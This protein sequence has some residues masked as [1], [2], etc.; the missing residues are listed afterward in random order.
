MPHTSEPEPEPTESPE[1]PGASE[2]SPEPL[3]INGVPSARQDKNG[4]PFHWLRGL[5]S[6]PKSP[7]E[8]TLREALEEVIEEFEDN[9]SETVAAH[10]RALISNI[11]KLR[12]MT[13]LDVMIPRADIVAIEE[14]TP[15]EELFQLLSE[16]QYSRMPVYRENLDQVI[17][18]IHI[19]D[20]L[21]ALSQGKHVVIS[22]LVRRVPIVSPAM[23]V[24]DLLLEMQHT[25][26]HMAMVVDEYGGIDGLVTIGDVIESIFGEIDDEFQKADEPEIIR[27]D[28][29][30]VVVD[31]RYDLEEFEE[32]YGVLTNNEDLEDVDTLGGLVSTVTGR[33][34]AR[35]EIVTLK[36]SN[37]KFEVLD[38]DPRRI[39]RLRIRNLKRPSLAAE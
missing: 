1:G 21:A 20:I 16:K 6:S 27:R 36:D 11:L 28:D 35:G 2:P 34:P 10:E 39:N 7:Q 24:P 31:A 15:A 18:T 19:K 4:K 5:V 12:D 9:G 37:V 8:G 38:A 26:K 23:P 30:S 3:N 33:I 32:E 17:G 22:D 29:G 14:G 25:T 13:V